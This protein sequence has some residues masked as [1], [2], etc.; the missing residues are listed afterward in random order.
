[1][2]WVL[3]PFVLCEEDS[4]VATCGIILGCMTLIEMQHLGVDDGVERRE[5][6][7]NAVFI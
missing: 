2:L 3:R 4:L 7:G 1:M 5:K 6:Y